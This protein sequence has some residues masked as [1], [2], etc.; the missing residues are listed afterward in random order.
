MN[1]SSTTTTKHTQTSTRLLVRI[2]LVTAITCILAPLSIP[3]PFSPVPLSLTNL[4]L[5]ISIF[6][7][8]WKSATVSYL[9]YLLLGTVGLPVFSGFAGGLGKLAGPTG[10]YLVGMI[11]LTILSGW[12][13]ERF[14]KKP[15]LIFIGM[16]L[17][18]A[19][20]YLFGTTWLCMQLHLSFAEGLMIGVVPYLFFDIAKML[21]A[22]FVG[23]TIQKR[24]KNQLL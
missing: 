4:V 19:V 1:S 10:G 3:L 23:L 12:I 24:L 8:G 15:V 7:L 9:V 22:L 13:A 14:S 16:L 5:Y 18:S 20:N 6:V 17:G 2:A 11:F 21:S